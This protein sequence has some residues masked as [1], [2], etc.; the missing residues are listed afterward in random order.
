[1]ADPAAAAAAANAASR[2]R[3]AK[4]CDTIDRQQ[5]LFALFDE[6]KGS[7]DYARWRRD[8]L[9][10]VDSAGKDFTAALLYT[11]PLAPEADYADA[12]VN[13]NEAAHH[14]P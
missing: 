2:T 14:E 6:T 12:L 10:F 5:H 11:L 8:L 7:A 3:V 9:L 1:M 4:I 13:V